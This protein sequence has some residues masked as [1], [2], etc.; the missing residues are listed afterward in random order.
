MHCMPSNRRGTHP[1]TQIILARPVLFS[2]R[3]LQD[4]LCQLE[5]IDQV[6]RHREFVWLS[7]LMFLAQLV[8]FFDPFLW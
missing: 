8:F 1:G 7:E 5:L 3:G 2:G 4:V 6:C